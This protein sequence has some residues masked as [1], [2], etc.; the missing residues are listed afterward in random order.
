MRL[1]SRM[2]LPAAVALVGACATTTPRELLDARTAY[3]RA[4]QGPAAT[5][6]PAE[7]HS[8]RETLTVAEQAFADH[9]D[10]DRTKDLAYAAERKA[11]LADV[12][13]H[14][15]AATQARTASAA[16]LQALKDEELRATSAELSDANQ[17]LSQQGGQLRNER[18][19]REDAERAAALAE[20]DL[21]RIASI[22]H[23]ARG[24]VIT[25][26]GGVLFES[27][28]SELLPA[29]QAKLTE[30]A[31][32]LTKQDVDSRIRVEGYTDSQGSLSFNEGL[33]QRRA[34]AVRAYLVGHG[35][36]ADRVTAVGFGPAKAIADN[37]S[38]EGRANNRRV[39]IVVQPAN[40]PADQP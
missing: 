32:A 35:I 30:V 27:A 20:A 8:A 1:A 10:S 22:K 9:G 31:D 15:V 4:S 25:L 29:A 12:R 2:V 16:Q 11:E 36:A 38:P 23:E 14:T 39:E 19:R 7:L 33:S 40:R 18:Q 3:D 26:S 37:A 17:R 6:A 28:K 24:M 34:D 21:A 5:L 13:A